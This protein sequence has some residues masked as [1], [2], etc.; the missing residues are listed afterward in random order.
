MLLLIE[1]KNHLLFM[2]MVAALFAC[3]GGGGSG[4]STT[5]TTPPATSAIQN[6]ADA[7]RISAAAIDAFNNLNYLVAYSTTGV[8]SEML[9]PPNSS[10]PPL[11][12][13]RACFNG[14]TYDAVL[15][16]ANG[17]GKISPGE[18]GDVTFHGCVSPV[19]NPSN[20][21]IHQHLINFDADFPPDSIFPTVIRRWDAEYTYTNY[22]RVD[23]ATNANY[24]IDG[25][26]AFTSAIRTTGAPGADFSVHAKNLQ[27]TSMFGISDIVDLSYTMAED[28]GANV[29]TIL[30][31]GSYRDAIA[32]SVNVTSSALTLNGIPPSTQITGTITL[33]SGLS[34]LTVVFTAT[35]VDFTL[36]TNGNG[37][38]V[39]TWSVPIQ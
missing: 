22:T 29:S 27:I 38:S 5:G 21:A 16:D 32:G 1:L 19:S 11:G 17:D 20:G 33:T 8:V 24:S 26:F 4:T 7:E 39:D 3:G 35:T 13:A 23:S 9:P 14:G 30:F 37:M 28:S 6:R 34:I 12:M 2:V 18:S 25:Y 10:A 36:D 15:F 31:T